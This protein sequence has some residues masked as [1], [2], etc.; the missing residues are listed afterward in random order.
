MYLLHSTLQLHLSQSINVEIWSN[1]CRQIGYSS[2]HSKSCEDKPCRDGNDKSSASSWSEPGAQRLKASRASS[3]AWSAGTMFN[4]C[5]SSGVFFSMIIKHVSS[6]GSRTP[7]HV[8]TQTCLPQFHGKTNQRHS[9][10]HCTLVMERHHR[11]K[12]DR[13]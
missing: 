8:L 4:R 12:H 9:Q 3:R 7:T 11:S 13:M 1:P 2:I 5:S 6:S 10:S